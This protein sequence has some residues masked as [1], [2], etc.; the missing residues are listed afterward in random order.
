MIEG[1]SSPFTASI[2]AD[3]VVGN[4][5]PPTM[6]LYDGSSDL[7]YHISQYKTNMRMKG[8][9]PSTMCSAFCLT[10]AGTAFEWFKD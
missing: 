9:S 8:Q 5:C 2:C 1:V 10:L 4:F 7:L 6:P 3:D